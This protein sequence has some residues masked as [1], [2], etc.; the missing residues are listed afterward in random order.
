MKD[1]MSIEELIEQI[2]ET[3]DPELVKKFSLLMGFWLHEK[4][5][6]HIIFSLILNVCVGLLMASIAKSFIV[7]D[8]NHPML[9]LELAL[10]IL[11]ICEFFFKKIII[12]KFPLLMLYTAGQVFTFL[13]FVIFGLMW[14]ALPGFGFSNFGLFIVFVLLFCIIR[15]LVS[16]AIRKMLAHIIISNDKY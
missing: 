2:Q 15:M 11:T 4:E 8:I 6:L 7:L 5:I 1:D 10:V 14:V 13:T 9:H 3:K 16:V 12:S